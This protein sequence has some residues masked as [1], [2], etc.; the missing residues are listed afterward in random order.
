MNLH[1][2]A[3]GNQFRPNNRGQR[4]IVWIFIINCSSLQLVFVSG[5]QAVNFKQAVSMLVMRQAVF[6]FFVPIGLLLSGCATTPKA[7]VSI[8][9]YQVSGNSAKTIERQLSLR[10]PHIPGKGRALA[11]AKISMQQRVQVAET[12]NWCRVANAEITIRAEVTLPKWKQRASAS[13]DLG[14]K[15][16]N[17]AAY[18][19]AHE[20]VHV[21]IA[22][23]YAGELERKLEAIPTQSDCKAVS[24][25]V[26]IISKDVVGEMNRAQDKFDADEERRIKLLSGAGA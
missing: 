3:A 20:R 10:G 24:K 23:K 7:D 19:E 8:G 14:R 13:N 4:I 25:I 9:Y 12:S 22:E 16:D 2:N 21:R 6:V 18:A 1:G 15:W 5:L 17:F 26:A 11:A